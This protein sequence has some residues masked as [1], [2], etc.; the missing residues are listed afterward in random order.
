MTN[1]EPRAHIA[2]SQAAAATPDRVL[3]A[4]RALVAAARVAA[5]SDLGDDLTVTVANRTMEVSLRAWTPKS[6]AAVSVVHRFIGDPIG[7]SDQLG[8]R[9][10][11]SLASAL[12]PGLEALAADGEVRLAGTG[13]RWRPVT[14]PLI[15]ALRGLERLHEPASEVAGTTVTSTAVMQVGHAVRSPARWSAKVRMFGAVCEVPVLRATIGTL[16]RA[17]ERGNEVEVSVRATWV[18]ADTGEWAFQ[19]RRSMIVAAKESPHAPLEAGEWS[20]LPPAFTADGARRMLR[21]GER[22]DE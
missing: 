8:Y 16:L 20:T 18:R 3:A 19:P 17:L 1:E 11:S 14:Q 12:R 9:I 6:E 22:W 13:T 4:V 2:L 7:T 15:E 21:E 5:G 10:A